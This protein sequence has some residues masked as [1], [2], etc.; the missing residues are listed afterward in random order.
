MH[1]CTERRSLEEQQS[2]RE[3]AKRDDQV[4]EVT[5]SLCNA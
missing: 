3:W 2:T 5:T 4:R 1:I